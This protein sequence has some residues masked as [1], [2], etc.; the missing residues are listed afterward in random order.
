MQFGSK[1][2][3][4]DH[5]SLSTFQIASGNFHSRN[6]IISFDITYVTNRWYPTLCA[7]TEYFFT[8]INTI[9]IVFTCIILAF[10]KIWKSVKDHHYFDTFSSLCLCHLF[11]MTRKIQEERE[12]SNWLI[13]FRYGSWVK[14]ECLRANAVVGK[15]LHLLHNLSVLW[16]SPTTIIIKVQ[17]KAK[18]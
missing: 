18:I 13:I 1:Y 9:S 6:M 12:N 7:I 16:S 14:L 10:I 3:I 11:K 5:W 4:S 17:F 2:S 15:D 8:I